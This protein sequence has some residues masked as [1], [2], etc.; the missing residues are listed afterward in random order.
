MDILKTL[1]WQDWGTNT[2]FGQFRFSKGY[3]QSE[4]V[5]EFYLEKEDI[6]QTLYKGP[7]KKEAIA[8]CE[9]AYLLELGEFLDEVFDRRAL[10]LLEA[11]ADRTLRDP[12]QSLFERGIAYGKAQF[13]KY[14]RGLIR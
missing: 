2:V 12:D 6:W 7:S 14:L 3:K 8:A 1:R 11:Q 4:I 13:S 9:K 10:D 5:A